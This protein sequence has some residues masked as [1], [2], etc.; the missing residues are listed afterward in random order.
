MSSVTITP[1]LPVSNTVEVSQT[2]SPVTLTITE[3]VIQH[4]VVVSPQNITNYYGGSG[5]VTA[6]L[7]GVPAGANDLGVGF[8]NIISD[9]IPIKDALIEL[10]A[11]VENNDADIS[12]NTTNISTNTSDITALETTVNGLSTGSLT[13]DLDPTETQL[14][15]SDPGTFT[16]GTPVETVL[17]QL[18][19]HFQPPTITGMTAQGIPA[20]TIEHGATDT[21]TQATWVVTNGSNIDAAVTG[22]ITYND[23]V[24]SDTQSY[25]S[26][27][28][29]DSP[30]VLNKNV[31]FKVDGGS[32]PGATGTT[33][34]QTNTYYLRISGFQ[35]TQGTPL[36]AS[37]D[38]MT[39]Q[40]RTFV[41]TS[42]TAISAG[43][44]TNN[45]GTALIAGAQQG[46]A[47][48]TIEHEGLHPSSLRQTTLSYPD[49]VNYWYAV[50]PQCHWDDVTAIT[51]NQG[52]DGFDITGTEV[53]CGSFVYTNP[54]GVD[55]TMQVIR[56]ASIGQIQSGKYIKFS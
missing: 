36:N 13:Q 9:N 15:F 20:T 41:L 3:Q 17:R 23:P 28:A 18:L 56:G 51:T 21:I 39:V 26:I 25:T 47:G 43:A 10:E 5:E 19:I 33:K 34:T 48:A 37:V 2:V 16:A 54:E 22:T 1:V 50:M 32:N 14:F 40:Y 31:T 27:A 49:T 6:A 35:D 29:T 45:T 42:P 44:V 30:Y 52:F 24:G 7:T 38:Y 53:N 12:N 11:A 8:G 4:T 55:V 46:T